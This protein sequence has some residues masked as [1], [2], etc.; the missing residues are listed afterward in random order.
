FT[1][2]AMPHIFGGQWPVIN[3][4]GSSHEDDPDVPM[5]AISVL[6]DGRGMP[7]GT[8]PFSSVTDHGPRRRLISGRRLPKM[9][10]HS[11]GSTETSAR[12]WGPVGFRRRAGFEGVG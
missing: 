11:H 10:V 7:Q 2:P 3:G 1:N 6:L 4:Q 9:I 12:D 5:P 8:S